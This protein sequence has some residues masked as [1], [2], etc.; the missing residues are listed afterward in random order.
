MS[1]RWILVTA[2][3]A[4]VALCFAAAFMEGANLAMAAAS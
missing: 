4:T 3:V 1:L 2:S